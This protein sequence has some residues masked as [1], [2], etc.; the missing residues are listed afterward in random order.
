MLLSSA[1]FFQKIIFGTL[2]MYKTV[3]I[4]IRTDLKVG[5]DLGSNSLQRLSADGKSRCIIAGKEFISQTGRF[6]TYDT[7]INMWL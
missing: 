7:E 4:Q 2:L 5:P 6:V 1:D 3:W